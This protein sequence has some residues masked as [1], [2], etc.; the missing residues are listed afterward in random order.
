MLSSCD[1]SIGRSVAS[2]RVFIFGVASCCSRGHKLFASSTAA[3]TTSIS[4]IIVMFF[5]FS[6]VNV[7]LQC[8]YVCFY[9]RSGGL[10][11]EQD[12]VLLREPHSERIRHLPLLT[13]QNKL[14]VPLSSYLH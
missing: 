11:S 10:V 1:R 7:D 9:F 3:A 12:E 6:E 4:T 8:D 2:L 5:A 14:S 13:S